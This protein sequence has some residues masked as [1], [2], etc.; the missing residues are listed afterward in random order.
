MEI[1]RSARIAAAE[2]AKTANFQQQQD[3]WVNNNNN[4][5]RPRRQ[6]GKIIYCGNEDVDA[7][8]EE[9][10]AKPIVLQRHEQT[11]I[12]INFIVHGIMKYEI[13]D[14]KAREMKGKTMHFLQLTF[15]FVLIK[16]ILWYFKVL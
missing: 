13:N 9:R 7:E 8:V 6:N 4:Y 10:K 11:S 3:L 5:V 1:R 16:S 12:F 2:S 15:A 14:P